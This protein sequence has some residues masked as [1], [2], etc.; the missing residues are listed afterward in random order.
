VR[1]LVKWRTDVPAGAD[2]GT[3]Y[4]LGSIPEGKVLTG[5][6]ISYYG[7]DSGHRIG[8]ALVPAGN[9]VSA[10]LTTDAG[11][12]TMAWV[13]PMNGAT[14]TAS[15]PAPVAPNLVPFQTS[16]PFTLVAHTTLAVTTAWDV[17]VVGMLEDL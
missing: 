6:T 16:G 4:P 13:Y 11:S 8:V 3:Q 12:G 15:T 17:Q 5:V 14:A 10:A 2:A 1:T 7:G 9:N